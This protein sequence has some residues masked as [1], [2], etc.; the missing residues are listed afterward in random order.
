M[1]MAAGLPIPKKVF[2]TGFINMGGEKM[3]KSLGN[4][5]NPMALADTYGPD[6]LRYYLLREVIFGLDGTYT[7]E[8][9]EGRFNGD[10]ANDLGNLV[11]RTLT[12]VDKYFGGVIPEAP[13]VFG[14]E[15]PSSTQ[16]NETRKLMDQLAFDVV[17]ENHW[18]HIKNANKYIQTSAPWNLA[19]DETKQPELQKVLFTLVEVLR[20]TAIRLSP[21]MPFTAQA[22][23]EQLGFQDKVEKHSFAETE[24]TGSYAPGQKIK[25]GSPLFPRIE[26]KKEGETAPV[27]GEDAVA[28]AQN[29]LKKKISQYFKERNLK[30]EMGWLATSSREYPE[31]LAKGKYGFYVR[32]P[33][34]KRVIIEVDAQKLADPQSAETL[35]QNLLTETQ[36]LLASAG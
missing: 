19:K 20:V 26:K 15:M 17:L 1:L 29:A 33:D 24:T 30:P 32:T 31:L 22:I 27:S 10:L 23:W 12:M 2:G 28:A 34:K 21:F 6:A 8:G 25:L 3:S 16:A 35:H 7:P 14:L 13:K 9:F 11:S 4:V 36:K 18:K 5:V